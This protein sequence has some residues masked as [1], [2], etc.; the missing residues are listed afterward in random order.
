MKV[1]KTSDSLMHFHDI[2]SNVILLIRRF[3]DYDIWSMLCLGDYDVWSTTTFRLKFVE[4]RRISVE[5]EPVFIL[6]F[7]F[8]L[9]PPSEKRSFA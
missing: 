1:L 9:L 5:T 7:S 3:F 6:L 4:L 2:S 8:L